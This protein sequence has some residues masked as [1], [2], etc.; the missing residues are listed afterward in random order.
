MLAVRYVALAALVVWLGGMVILGLVVAPS[1]FGVL[2]SSDPVNG[3]M[4]AGAVFGTILRRFHF[5]AYAC[6]AILF[7]SLFVMKFVGPP[8]Q[9]FVVRAGIVF[10]MLLLAL[11]SGVPVTRELEQLQ[12]QVS[13]PISRLPETD[14]RRIR[15]D[16]LHR[17][18]TMLMTINMA[19]GLVLLY[20]YVRE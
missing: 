16:Q 15:F 3:R 1:T 13:G 6:A 17:T 11:Y 2:Q 14:Q 5:I 18:S 19:L 7:V 4:L 9:A 8:P 12:S 10:V 20:W